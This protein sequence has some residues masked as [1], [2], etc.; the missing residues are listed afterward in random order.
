M[1]AI[2]SMDRKPKDRETIV[3]ARLPESRAREDESREG[4][5]QDGL[6]DALDGNI[7]KTSWTMNS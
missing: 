2:W 5:G 4:Q 1:S 7:G 3:L 6:E